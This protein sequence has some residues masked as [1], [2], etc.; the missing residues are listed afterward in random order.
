[1]EDSAKA[2]SAGEL[3]TLLV[4]SA[5]G[6][7]VA[8]AFWNSSHRIWAVMG[9]L[10]ALGGAFMLCVAVI[11]HL[12]YALTPSASLRAQ[13][14]VA[15][16]SFGIPA[17]LL[18]DAD[19]ARLAAWEHHGYPFPGW[20]VLLAVVGGVFALGMGAQVA[21]KRRSPWA[22]HFIAAA[23][24][25]LIASLAS[26]GAHRDDIK[27]YD[28][29]IEAALSVSRESAYEYSELRVQ[30]VAEYAPRSVVF[31]LGAGVAYLGLFLGMRPKA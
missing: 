22:L 29:Q 28:R 31:L 25:A 9:G 19:A 11:K 8:A 6:W 12:A 3:V 10:V 5:A 13:V 1:M 23:G 27:G 14:A 7:G 26:E 30:A 2:P 18:L 17:L 16:L 24:L 21:A 15:V 20:L 4:L